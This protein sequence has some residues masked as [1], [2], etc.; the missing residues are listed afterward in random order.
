M[1]EIT[2][3]EF[4]AVSALNAEYR[5]SFFLQKLKEHEIVVFIC[6]G[7]DLFLLGDDSED[8]DGV[9]STVMPVFCHPRFAQ[10]LIDSFDDKKEDLKV[11]SL[12]VKDFKDNLSAPLQAESILLGIMPV[13]QSYFTVLEPDFSKGE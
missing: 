3:K 10:A 11:V 1:F 12:S 8:E 7:D 9:K 5:E 4:E 2:D 6:Q 13:G